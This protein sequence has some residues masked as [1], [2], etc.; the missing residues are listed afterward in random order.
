MIDGV[1]CFGQ[2]YECSECVIIIFKGLVDRINEMDDFKNTSVS[3]ESIHSRLL[4]IDNS[5]LPI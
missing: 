3:L 2:I 4:A 1:K 5:V